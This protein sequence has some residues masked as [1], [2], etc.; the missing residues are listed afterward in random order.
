MKVVRLSALFAAVL[1]CTS[2]AFAADPAQVHLKG[3]ITSV[4]SSSFDMT[5]STGD[6]PVEWNA[7]TRIASLEPA[8]LADITQG[9][10]VGTAAVPEPDGRLKAV[11]VHIFPEELR[12]TGEGFRPFPQLPQGTMTNATVTDIVGTQ[13]SVSDD[14]LTLTLKYKDGEKKVR[15][16]K[17]TPIVLLGAGD[18]SLLK[19]QAKVSVTGA[20]D[21]SGKLIATRILVGL[22]GVTPPM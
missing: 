1:V 10:F 6:V 12:G 17:G 21:G 16:P 4:A 19:P 8:K 14:D 22:D 9:M 11:E 18:A 3:Q 5:S 7:K 2:G 20:K 13:G 15:V